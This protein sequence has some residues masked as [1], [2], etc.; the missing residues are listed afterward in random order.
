M[1]ACATIH[2]PSQQIR[3]GAIRV[4]ITFS[5]GAFS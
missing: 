4:I 2:T 5:M 3:I 1:S